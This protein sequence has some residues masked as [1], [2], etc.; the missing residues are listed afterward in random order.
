[1]RR[2][3]ASP[4]LWQRFGWPLLGI[5]CGLA[6]LAALIS[7]LVLESQQPR[8]LRQRADDLAS[9]IIH[10]ADCVEHVGQLQRFLT[11]LGTERDLDLVVLV[12]GDPLRVV[13][14]N[15]QG[16]EGRPPPDT[17]IFTSVPTNFKSG[18]EIKPRWHFFAD[19]GK[20]ELSVPFSLRPSSSESLGF[21]RGLIVLRL[22]H[23]WMSGQMG[24]GVV[25]LLIEGGLAIGLCGAALVLL[26]Q[27]V[28]RPLRT[29]QESLLQAP[30]SG[31]ESSRITALVPDEIGQLNSALHRALTDATLMRQ[32]V[33]SS[34][35]SVVIT[36]PR[37][38]GNP[39]IYVNPAFCKVTGYSADEALGCNPRLLQGT[40]HDQEGV[41]RLHVA[42]A[43][44]HA[45]AAVLRNYRK[46]GSLF[47]NQMHI[48]PVR[49]AAGTLCA[50]IGIASDISDQ[51]RQEEELR[52]TKA[53]LDAIVEY[54]P[55]A[56][57]CKDADQRC[58][59]LWNHAAERLFSL[60]ASQVLGKCD[61][62]LFPPEQA[63]AFR[64]KDDAV[65]LGNDPGEIPE[66]PLTPPTGPMRWLRT[67]KVPIT[68]PD[69][70]ARYLLGLSEDITL[71]RQQELR[72]RAAHAEAE[73]LL[74][75]IS[76]I[77]IQVD[78]QDRILRFN[79]AAE[80]VFA[81]PSSA[82]L[83]RALNES[84][85]RL[86]WGEIIPLIL[87]TL[88][89]Q[90]VQELHDLR[91]TRPDGSEVFLD[92]YLT[93]APAGA[94]SQR[95]SILLLGHDV[96]R[97][98]EQEALRSQGQKLES[99][100]QLAAGIAHEI[101]TP[102]QFIGD[103]L[104][105]LADSF[106]DLGRHRCASEAA[107]SAS[108]TAEAP[109]LLAEVQRV[110]HEVDMPF[111][112]EEVPKAIAQ[113]LEGVERVADIVRAM[114]AFSHP[115]Q[116]D[117]KCPVDLNQALKTTFVVARN[118]YKYAAELITD[119]DPAL[120]LVPGH[121]GELN[122]VFL[123]LLVNAAHAIIAKNHGTEQR[124][125]I[126]VS[127]RRVGDYAELRLTDS[128]NGI[129]PE[130]RARIFTPFFTTKPVGKGTGQGLALCHGIITKKHGGTIGFESEP[131]T[132]TTFIIRLPFSTSGTV[133]AQEKS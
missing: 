16:W 31:L 46:N 126:T 52:T 21:S 74:S 7:M 36:D 41:R 38:P 94:D 6:L 64:A 73:N 45:C 37:R 116:G 9:T 34:E 53:F 123:N 118:E 91:C 39:I 8:R 28:L 3:P 19:E 86:D 133:T 10:V 61:E 132:G 103:N 63:A 127:S 48:A 56:V 67:R 49:N 108:A 59:R 130:H 122:Q 82:V 121:A 17:N 76:T 18:E 68:G 62:D 5:G 87:T 47:W 30:Y 77:L 88:L 107:L 102:I 33:D 131:G 13:A 98:R 12:A 96:T 43:E 124:G 112:I 85:L 128:G 125:T 2:S 105:F 58:F 15:R 54:L 113:S 100:G 35:N 95:P 115:D 99:I 27:R 72:L 11:A 114:K 57:F 80:R 101:N 50:F 93:P 109:A 104:R 81:L 84:G 51:R 117:E 24:D 20:A 14:A 110:A 25:F 129:K 89:E 92:L 42:V 65:L 4:Q 44:G 106:G 78:D 1:M 79:A 69:G 71:Q 66:E 32:A 111:L 119:L 26:R 29:V 22:N 75:V 40:D 90:R 60:P 55:V 120:P 83:G 97:R 23:R 70:R